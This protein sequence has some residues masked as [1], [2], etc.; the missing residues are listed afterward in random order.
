MKRDLAER[1]AATTVEG[2]TFDQ[3]REIIG[4]FLTEIA[5]CPVCDGSGEI[6]FARDVQISTTE[7]GRAS[8]DGRRYIEKGTV[9]SCPLCGSTEPSESARGDPEFVAWHC[10]QGD[11]NRDCWNDREHPDRRDSHVSCGLRVMLPLEKGRTSPLGGAEQ[12]LAL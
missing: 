12:D 10:E 2:V 5:R 8:G 4:A 3:A 11:S 7:P 6:T 1:I 9:G